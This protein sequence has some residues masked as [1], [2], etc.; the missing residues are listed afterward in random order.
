MAALNG[1][2]LIVWNEAATFILPEEEMMWMD[3]LS[4]LT[5][6]LPS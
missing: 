2:R 1:A 6:R 5:K 3:S 4:A